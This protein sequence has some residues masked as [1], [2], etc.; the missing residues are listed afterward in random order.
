M[1]LHVII[2]DRQNTASLQNNQSHAIIDQERAFSY[3]NVCSYHLLIYEVSF[4]STGESISYKGTLPK[5]QR[6][7]GL[8]SYTNVTAFR[9]HQ[10]SASDPLDPDP[11][12]T[13]D[14]IS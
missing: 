9:K 2:E 6:A 12:Q 13:S 5:A 1:I 10:N 3:K 8:S 14:S 11:Y 7:R 4:W